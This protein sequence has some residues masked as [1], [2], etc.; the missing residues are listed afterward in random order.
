STGVSGVVSET[1]SLVGSNPGDQVGYGGTLL[2]NGNYVVRSPIWNDNRG[3]L[4]WGSGAAAV[5]GVV[6][7]DNSLVGSN[8][9]DS[10]CSSGI[11]QLSNGNFVVDS[12]VWNGNRGAL[13][14]GSG[15]AGVSGVVSET[16]SLV[17]SHPNDQVGNYFS[18]AALSNGNY[19]VLI[20]N[21]NDQRGA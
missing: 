1:N 17:G 6:S 21:W 14:W 16:N 5:R 11:T 20:P 10:V 3:A 9:D 15:T 8:P 13:T 2:S 12:P 18:V 7:A 19:A 4:T